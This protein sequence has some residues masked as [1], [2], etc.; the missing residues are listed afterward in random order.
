MSIKYKTKIISTSLIFSLFN[1]L[2]FYSCKQSEAS[3]PVNVF[4]PSSIAQLS[5]TDHISQIVFTSDL[6]Y[7]LKRAFRGKVV[8]A[9]VVN[10]AMV[11]QIN[12]LPEAVFPQDKGIN[13]GRKVGFIDYVAINGDI[14]NRQQS[15]IQSASVSWNQFE[16]DYLKGIHLKNKKNN[17]AEFLLTCGNHDVANAIGFSKTLNPATD[18]SVMVN[19][20]NLMLHPIPQK[21]F[22]NYNYSSDKPN[23]SK[24]IDGIHFM[25]ITMWPD[26]AAQIWMEKDLSPI[27]SNTPALIFTHDPIAGEPTH[28]TNPLG[29]HSMNE[30][31]ENEVEENFRGSLALQKELAVF[32]KN[33][34]NIKAYF[35]GHTN[36]NQ[37]YTFVGPDG[38]L[39]IKVFRVDS[40]MKGEFSETDETKLSFQ[41][42][43]LDARNQLLTVRECF[44]NQSGT[45]SVINWGAS[46]TISLSQNK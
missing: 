4:I 42:L 31:Y 19:I 12:L 39:D 13:A 15:G 27:D 46:S 44:W 33:H 45:Y 37:F 16:T 21:T 11:S 9:N 18:N 2:I 8:D 38:N 6:H 14:S 25:F 1:C 5:D 17:E 41:V 32:F 36:Y 22:R 7:G 10:E 28:F 29:N 30:N 43:S 35:H 26:S 3:S 23:F 24:D 40:P 34:P 20:Y